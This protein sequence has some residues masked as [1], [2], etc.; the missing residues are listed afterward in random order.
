MK[1]Y[2]LLAF[3]SVSVQ[4]SEIDSLILTSDSV[5]QTFDLGIKT[6]AGQVDYAGVGGISPDMASAA[7]LTYDQAEAYNQSLQAVSTM[8]STM[9]AQEYFDD[10]AQQAMDSL[11]TA[12][13]NYVNAASQLVMAVQ[14]NDMAGN[15][16]NTEQAVEIQ[17]YITN[18]ELSIS[19][20]QVDTYNDS[21]D[22]VQASA[23]TAASFMAIAS[24]VQLVDSAQEQAD[25]LGESFYFAEAA[26]YSQGNFTVDLN[27]GG[28]TLDVSGYIKT[29]E[30]VLAMGEES[31]FYSTS[32]TGNECFFTQESCD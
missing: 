18:N 31:S 23:Q 19:T 26:Y 20:D 2:L 22:L 28:I 21:L 6:V 25:A 3:L 9:T 12:V 30:E 10:Q 29:A 32:P 14:V 1:K 13:D 24:D 16:K 7:H 27:S 11:G 5:K 17:T 4:A 15:V 8:N